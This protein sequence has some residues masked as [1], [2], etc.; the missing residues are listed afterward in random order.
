MRKPCPA[1]EE[2]VTPA[3][4]I[5]GLDVSERR[6]GYAIANYDT[7]RIVETG[8]MHTPAGDD[9]N[10]RVQ[11][12]HSISHAAN[13][14]GDIQLV[15]IEAPWSGPNRQG[16][17]RGAMA[18]GNLAGIAATRL[19]RTVLVDTIQPTQW[20]ALC[21]ISTRG[22]EPVM[23]WATSVLGRSVTQD[24]AD[25]TGIATAAHHIAWNRNTT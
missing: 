16:S 3:A 15:L 4:V 23:E 20:R 6:I 5:I 18:V 14:T 17:I 2:V 25:A 19:G 21:G 11:A 12:W 10:T 9:L 24:E 8:V 7:G 13:Q 1:R 22:K